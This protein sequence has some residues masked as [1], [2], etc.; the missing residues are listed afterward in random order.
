MIIDLSKSF[1]YQAMT[2]YVIHI[3]KLELA[4]SEGWFYV[5][6]DNEYNVP[7]LNTN[8]QKN[9]FLNGLINT[10]FDLD[11][12]TI[13]KLSDSI[14][15]LQLSNRYGADDRVVVMMQYNSYSYPY[16]EKLFNK[17]I[18]ESFDMVLKSIE[19]HENHFNKEKPVEKFSLK[20]YLDKLGT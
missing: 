17:D 16:L 2:S 12:N 14:Y 19:F 10:I 6:L 13:K 7:Q 18:D 15:N 11:E 8:E 4:P 3:T 20:T 9:I 1:S 5:I